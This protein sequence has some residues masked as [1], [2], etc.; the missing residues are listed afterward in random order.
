LAAYNALIL[1]GH[2]TF[3]LQLVVVTCGQIEGIFAT[4]RSQKQYTI[5]PT[6]DYYKLMHSIKLDCAGYYLVKVIQN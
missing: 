1:S 3:T 2:I 5:Y 4:Q 6:L